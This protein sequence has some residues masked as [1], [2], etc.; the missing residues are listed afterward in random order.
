MALTWH[1]RRAPFGARHSSRSTFLRRRQRGRL[2]ERVEAPP[3]ELAGHADEQRGADR[4]HRLAEPLLIVP[5][6]T[7]AR[8]QEMHITLGQMLCDALEQQC[9]RPT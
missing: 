3:E 6:D 5:S 1:P 9:T 2:G 7:I 4:E 8:I